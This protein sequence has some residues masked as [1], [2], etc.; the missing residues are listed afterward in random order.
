M[1]TLRD[2]HEHVCGPVRSRIPVLPGLRLRDA[3]LPLSVAEIK[4]YN[5]QFL[6]LRKYPNDSS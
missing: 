3:T 5:K 2:V 4:E 6:Q 1:H